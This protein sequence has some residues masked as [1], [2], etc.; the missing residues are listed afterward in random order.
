M[1][2]KFNLTLN[3]L[4]KLIDLKRHLEFIIPLSWQKKLYEI[5]LLVNKAINFNDRSYLPL[6]AWRLCHEA[7]KTDLYSDMFQFLKQKKDELA[8]T[9][10]F[11]N[12][13]NYDWI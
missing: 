5:A 7:A 4:V 2:E 9:I 10:K 3:Q 6:I 13:Y 11:K 12:N 8:K 1:K